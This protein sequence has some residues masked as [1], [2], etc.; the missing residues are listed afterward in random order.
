MGTNTGIR[1]SKRGIPA[2]NAPP[3]QRLLD[4]EHPLF[5]VFMEAEDSIFLPG[6]LSTN[7]KIINHNLGYR[8]VAFV[9]GQ[10]EAGS[11]KRYL[12]PGRNPFL[13]SGEEVFMWA[14]VSTTELVVEIE[15]PGPLGVDKTFQFHYYIMYDNAESL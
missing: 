5:K 12:I 6:A 1:I 14:H 2:Q 7:N 4:E 15:A 3:E 8:P 10:I 9:Y 11:A 13:Y